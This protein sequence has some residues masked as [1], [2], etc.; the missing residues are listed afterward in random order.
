MLFDLPHILFIVF[1]TL[2][3][4]IALVLCRLFIKEQNKKDLVLKIAALLTI[5]IH[6]S[7]LYV[8]YFSTGS[9]EI[10]N[11]MILPMYPCNV[12]MWLLLIVAFYK[13]KESKAFNILAIITFYLGLVGGI[14]GIVL[15]EI[16]SSTPNLADWD[17]LHGLL[18]HVT[19]LLGCIYILVGGYIKIRVSNLTS[20]IIGL[21]GL[22]VDGYLMI[23]LF[24][25]FNL[26]PPNI[27]FLLEPPIKAMPWF[28]TY[29]IDL[30]AIVLFFIVT[31]LCEQFTV[32]KEDRWYNKLNFRRKK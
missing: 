19:L 3:L 1:S 5:I 14:F 31:A 32:K 27:M 12:A 15:N 29:I 9:A 8:D 13:N 25:L 28:N 2:G 11:T 18:S 26:D 22:L 6:Y 16:Y 7:V 21:L 23:G 30:L 4:I 17:V 24:K 20:I 10:S